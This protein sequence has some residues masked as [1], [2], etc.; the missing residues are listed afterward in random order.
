MIPKETWK[1]EYKRG[2]QRGHPK[3]GWYYFF[4]GN[5]YGVFAMQKEAEK[6]WREKFADDPCLRIGIKP[7]LVYFGV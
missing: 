4:R 2:W 7:R 1:P 6:A 3:T 5:G